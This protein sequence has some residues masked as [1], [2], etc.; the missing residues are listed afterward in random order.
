MSVLGFLVVRALMQPA[1]PAG[2]AWVTP[3]LAWAASALL[4]LRG[5][6]GLA[7]DWVRDPIWWPTYLIGGILF[8]TVAWLERR[9]SVIGLATGRRRNARQRPFGIRT[10]TILELRNTTE[11]EQVPTRGRLEM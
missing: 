11:P 9:P 4:T 5:A 3:T 7:V 2:R 8:G 6:A 10:V 1:C